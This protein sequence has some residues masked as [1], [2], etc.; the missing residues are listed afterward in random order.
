MPGSKSD[1]LEKKYLDDTYGSGNPAMLYL[2]LYTI[3]PTD[4]GGGTEVSGGGYTRLAVVNNTTN[5][6][7]AI[8]NSPASK[9]NGTVLLF[10]E[11][12]APWGQVVAW[13]W[14]DASS[15]GNQLHWATLTEFKD[16]AAGDTARFDPGD[17]VMTED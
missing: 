16:I 17:L 13:A 15:G 6:P 8:G 4:A 12:S 5:F 3:A 9:S 2:A 7:A 14:K 1:Y 10:A 11:A